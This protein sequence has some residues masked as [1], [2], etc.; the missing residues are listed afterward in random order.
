MPE[1]SS[2]LTKQEKETIRKTCGN[3]VSPMFQTVAK[4]YVCPRDGSRWTDSGVWGAICL[5]VDR[6]L[7]PPAYMIQI[8]DLRNYSVQFCHELAVGCVYNSSDGL[9]HSFESDNGFI[10]FSFVNAAE[11]REF[12]QKVLCAIPKRDVVPSVVPRSHAFKSVVARLPGMQRGVNIGVPT[13]FVHSQ[14][15]AYNPAT[16]W[17]CSNV[18]EAWK[19]LFRS[20]GIRKVDLQSSATAAIIY[21]ELENEYGENFLE[22]APPV[23]PQPPPRAKGP[24]KPRVEAKIVEQV[25]EC[26]DC[27]PAPAAPDCLPPPPPLFSGPAAT[28]S[29]RG[30]LLADISKGGFKLKKVSEEEKSAPVDT[31]PSDDTLLS[32]LTRAINRRGE[33]VLTLD[34]DPDVDG[35]SD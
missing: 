3:M 19:S 5:V 2:T 35:W 14:H 15:I 27:P 33:F 24:Q 28:K 10:G 21:D 22:R 1:G 6:S 31:Q 11:A 13:N 23:V 34:E 20:R 32:V 4:L 29:A 26:P 18:P 16:G 25:P 12:G 7:Q 9:F 30:D 8:L 17:E